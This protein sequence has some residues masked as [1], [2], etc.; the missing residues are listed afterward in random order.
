MKSTLLKLPAEIWYQIFTT[1]TYFDLHERLKPANRLFRSLV[2]GS[3]VRLHGLTATIWNQ[4]IHHELDYH[5]LRSL[6]R[7]SPDFRFFV[8]RNKSDDIL[9]TRRRLP[10]HRRPGGLNPAQIT[11]HPAD[12]QGTRLE[13]H[14]FFYNMAMDKKKALF[15]YMAPS[16]RPRFVAAKSL[17]IDRFVYSTQQPRGFFAPRT[18]LSENAT[19]PPVAGFAIELN[20]TRKVQVWPKQADG[21]PAAITV[22]DVLQVLGEA[23]DTTLQ[24]GLVHGEFYTV[25]QELSSKNVRGCMS[26]SLFASYVGEFGGVKLLEPK[27]ETYLNGKKELSCSLSPPQLEKLYPPLV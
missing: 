22:G 14:P 5:D 20:K 25:F 4:V 1:L 18:V 19:Y 17:S 6:S 21:R 27:F 10:L 11:L 3:K 12:L 9:T 13:L 7:V 16:A 2:V 26:L 24:L 8:K 15:F 23:I